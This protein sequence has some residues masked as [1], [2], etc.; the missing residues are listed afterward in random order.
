VT[1]SGQHLADLPNTA[2]AIGT[3][4]TT[5]LD[6]PEAAR[7]ATDLFGDAAIGDAFADAHEH[8]WLTQVDDDGVDNRFQRCKTI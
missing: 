5:L 4:L 2:L 7:S 1:L 3:R 8:G 6:L